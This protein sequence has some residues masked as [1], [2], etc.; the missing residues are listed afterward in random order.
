MNFNYEVDFNNYQYIPGISIERFTA[1]DGQLYISSE[2]LED[3]SDKDFVISQTF[4]KK[5]NKVYLSY[6]NMHYGTIIVSNNKEKL[7]YTFSHQLDNTLYYQLI[8]NKKDTFKKNTLEKNN[9]KSYLLIDL[10]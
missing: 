1:K 9:E 3:C 5:R 8:N 4:Y 10:V 2:E 6:R 7:F